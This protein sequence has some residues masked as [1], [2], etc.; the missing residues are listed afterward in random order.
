[1]VVK[2]ESETT[3][4]TACKLSHLVI[5]DMLDSL[6]FRISDISYKLLIMVMLKFYLLLQKVGLIMWK[7]IRSS[8]KL[9]RYGDL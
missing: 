8:D 2:V 5:Q 3:E 7:G 4:V 9:F 6:D 1:M